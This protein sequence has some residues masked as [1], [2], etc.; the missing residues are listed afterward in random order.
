MYFEIGFKIGEGLWFLYVEMRKR[1]LR[2]KEK[3]IVFVFLSYNN[4]VCKVLSVLEI[5][6][7]L[8]FIIFIFYGWN[9]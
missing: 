3:S 1:I 6:V 5:L 7:Y 2:V 8:F 9:W 4:I